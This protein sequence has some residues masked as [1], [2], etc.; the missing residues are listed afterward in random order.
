MIRLIQRYLPSATFVSHF[1]ANMAAPVTWLASSSTAASVYLVTMETNVNTESTLA[2][3]IPATT[4]ARAGFLMTTE[5]Q[6]VSVQLG[7][8]VIDAKRI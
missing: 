7:L 5:G 3:A 2:L 8:K 1:H 4:A 6:A